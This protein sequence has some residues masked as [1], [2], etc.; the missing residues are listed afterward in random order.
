MNLYSLCVVPSV[1]AASSTKP[2]GATRASRR[3]SSSSAVQPTFQSQQLTLQSTPAP[4]LLSCTEGVQPSH[5]PSKRQK[6]AASV[7]KPCGSSH[8]NEAQE[9]QTL[10]GSVQE[11]NR[12][13]PGV[14]HTEDAAATTA[15]NQNK[16]E[17]SVLEG[18]GQNHTAKAQEG[19]LASAG[20]EDG[21]AVTCTCLVHARMTACQGCQPSFKSQQQVQCCMSCTNHQFCRFKIRSLLKL[22]Y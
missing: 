1:T 19:D 16:S 21:F 10:K 17:A 11:G 6:T 4:P 2:T 13:L 7:D 5:S 15:G 22:S 20:M 12:Q 9:R 3:T 18:N 14:R 8:S